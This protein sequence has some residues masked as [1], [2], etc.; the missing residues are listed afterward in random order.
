MQAKN[1]KPY[2]Y[3]IVGV[4]GDKLTHSKKGRTVMSD[5]ERYEALRHCRYVDEI[6]TNAPWTHTD[7]FIA[8]HKID[9]IAHDDEPYAAAGA[10]DIYAPIKVS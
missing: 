7:E 8:K 2:T 6:I 4:C 1:L 10:T 3:L 9:L 5:T